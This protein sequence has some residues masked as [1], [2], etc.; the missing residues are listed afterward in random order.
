MKFLSSRLLD[1]FLVS[2]CFE[3]G[4]GE[5]EPCIVVDCFELEKLVILV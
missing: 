4:N 5:D 3:P 1:L 2:T